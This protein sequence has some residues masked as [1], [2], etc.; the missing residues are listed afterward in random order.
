MAIFIFYCKSNPRTGSLMMTNFIHLKDFK[1]LNART[2]ALTHRVNKSSSFS[3]LD[4]FF[5]IK[6]TLHS[7]EFSTI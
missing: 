3:V 7:V 2:F 4:R 1:T 6:D 5:L